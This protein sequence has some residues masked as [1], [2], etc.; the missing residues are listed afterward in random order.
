MKS[1]YIQYNRR[2][3]FNI[4]PKSRVLNKIIKFEPINLKSGL[5]QIYEYFAYVNS[6]QGLQRS[7]AITT[8]DVKS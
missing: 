5:N 2:K 1:T 8:E 7:R 6:L 4:I 3:E